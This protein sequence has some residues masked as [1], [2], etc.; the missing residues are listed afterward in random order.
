MYTISDFEN[1]VK[2]LNEGIGNEGFNP[3]TSISKLFQGVKQYFHGKMLGLDKPIVLADVSA[4]KKVVNS[5]NYTEVMDTLIFQP[6]RLNKPYREL[7]PTLE[8]CCRFLTA[9]EQALPAV[10]KSLLD[11]SNGAGISIYSVTPL[12]ASKDKLE[13]DL[14]KTFN[15][16]EITDIAFSARFESM[17]DYQ[18]TYAD[19]NILVQKLVRRNPKETRL[20]VERIAEIAEVIHTSMTDG[21]VVLSAQQVKQLGDLMLQLARTVDV[22]SVATTLLISTGSALNNTA[23]KLLTKK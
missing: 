21:S 5:F 10:L 19:F 8:H 22:Y 17:T 9:T 2:D 23:E 18:G 20:N 11:I 15:G 13:L 14:Q 16:R 12:T 1:A 3:V 7:L 4:A 6:A